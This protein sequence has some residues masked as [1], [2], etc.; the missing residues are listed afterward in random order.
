MAGE[1]ARRKVAHVDITLAVLGPSRSEGISIFVALDA[2]MRRH[3]AEDDLAGGEEGCDLL[4]D[5]CDERKISSSGRTVR[6]RKDGQAAIREQMGSALAWSGV[7]TMI[8]SEEV[9]EHTDSPDFTLVIGARAEGSSGL[10]TSAQACGWRG[11]VEMNR[12]RAAG[13]DFLGTVAQRSTISK[14]H[15]VVVWHCP[16]ELGAVS[17]SRCL[18]GRGAFAR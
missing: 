4:A 13:A 11:R 15:G 12:T 8:G 9:N 10:R 5:G 18:L 1:D 3:P 7:R 16:N 17:P 6:D 14:S 2:H